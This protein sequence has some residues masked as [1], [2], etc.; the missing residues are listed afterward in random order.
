VTRTIPLNTQ[1]PTASAMF[2]VTD[3]AL[4]FA[5]VSVLFILQESNLND[6]TSSQAILQRFFNSARPGALGGGVTIDRA[7]NLT[8]GNGNSVD[9]V[10]F[11][12]STRKGVVGT[13]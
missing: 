6:A 10:N 7:Q 11:L 8:L 3:D 9:L 4:D 5:R 1:T 13:S 12:L 2:D